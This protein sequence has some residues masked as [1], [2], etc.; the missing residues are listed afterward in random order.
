MTVA[1]ADAKRLARVTEEKPYI[2]TPDLVYADDTMLLSSSAETAQ[3]LLDQV[4]EIGKSY[5]LEL[6]LGKTVCLC[7]RGREPILDPN[8][9]PLQ[10]KTEAVYLGGLLCTDGQYDRELTRR[11][12]EGRCSFKKIAAVWKHANIS[13]KRKHKVFEACVV[14]KLLYGL[15]SVWLLKAALQ[16]L[17]AFYLYCLRIIG[18]VKPSMVSRISNQEVLKIF[19]AQPLSHTLQRRQIL[20][21]VKLVKQPSHSLPRKIAIE[22]GDEKPKDWTPKRRVGRPS[23]RWPECVFKL[24]LGMFN[25]N[26]SALRVALDAPATNFWRTASRTLALL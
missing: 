5:G 25:D 8:G 21:Y 2:V 15:E 24:M 10:V 20:L 12:A 17:D 9:T 23:Q 7:V 26:R 18:G 11:I 19:E 4:I 3:R 16:R 1:M 6:N 22:Q 13:R 14:S